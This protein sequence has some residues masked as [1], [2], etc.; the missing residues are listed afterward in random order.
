MASQWER[1]CLKALVE[2]FAAFARAEW[3]Q[4]VRLMSPD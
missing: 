2:L 4:S 3:A 1:E